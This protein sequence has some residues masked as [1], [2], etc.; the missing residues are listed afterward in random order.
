M[1]LH[2]SF[3][4]K[5]SSKKTFQSRQSHNIVYAAKVKDILNPEGFYYFIIVFV[6]PGKKGFLPKHKLISW[7][8]NLLC[9]MVELAGVGVRN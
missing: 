7:Q 1:P 6:G 2:G 9:I 8:Y 5:Y 3:M 4:C